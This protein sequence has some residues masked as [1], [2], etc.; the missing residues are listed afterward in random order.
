MNRSFKRIRMVLSVPRLL[1]HLI[2]LLAGPQ[3]GVVRADLIRWAAAMQLKQPTSTWELIGWFIE[4]M[5]FLPEFRTLF[6]L[7]N[8]KSSWPFI[9]LCPR[10][11]DLVFDVGSIGPGLFIQHGDSTFVSAE[12]IG[13]NCT[14]GRHVIIGYSNLTDRPTIGDN[15]RIHPGA[16]IVGKVKLGDNSVVGLNSV[17]IGNVKPNMTVFGVPAKAIWRNKPPAQ[18]AGGPAVR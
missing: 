16:K 2:F 18:E 10:M 9:W 17:V 7:R 11:R 12:S 15:V 8:G 14:I 1:P 4:C 13:A 6:Y 3:R 5:T